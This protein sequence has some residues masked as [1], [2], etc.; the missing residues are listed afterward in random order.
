M[1]AFILK[2]KYE[3]VTTG[4]KDLSEISE[5]K[6]SQQMCCPDNFIESWQ[7][8]QSLEG[9]KDSLCLHLQF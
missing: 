8:S 4:L 2:G 6:V 3:A 9:S 5:T 7:R 1:L